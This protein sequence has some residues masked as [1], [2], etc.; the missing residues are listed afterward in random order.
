MG[1]EL[2]TH[3]FMEDNPYTNYPDAT[4]DGPPVRTSGAPAPS[5]ALGH[6]QCELKRLSTQA[7]LFEPFTRRMFE[8]AGL[9]R[10]MRVL[11]VGSGN[12][13]VAFLAALFVGESGEVL[14]VDKSPAAVQAAKARA[15]AAGLK[16]VTFTAGDL[17]TM[18]FARPFDAVIGRLVLMYQADPVAV[19]R[20]L[21]RQLKPGGV[22]AFQ[23]FDVEAAKCFPESPTFRQVMGWI[24]AA[25]EKTGADNRM[26]LK[27]Y[28]TFVAAG[29]PEPSMSLEASIG[30]GEK[31]PGSLLLP[32]VIRSLLPVIERLG[33]AAAGQ[34]QIESLDSRV[35]AEIA[36]LGA[37]TIL[38][39]LIG[40][41]AK[42]SIS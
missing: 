42:L 16:N 29:L 25:L 23:E 2:G 22:I 19:L 33:I 24:R 9:T 10:G 39:T 26:G 20:R 28:S 15:K 37:V 7:T 14:G 3:D 31:N 34:V 21:A 12:G 17:T 6:S 11:D 41:W 30:G 35:R 18:F 40:A 1:S 36:E 5:Y 38:P 8:Q 13:D 27:L 32:E 4:A